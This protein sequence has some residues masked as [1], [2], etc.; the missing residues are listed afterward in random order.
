MA[1]WIDQT[2]KINQDAEI[3]LKE[4][5]VYIYDP[6]YERGVCLDP[7]SPDDAFAMCIALKL[8]AKRLQDIGENKKYWEAPEGGR[9]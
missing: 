9:V 7:V 8:A 5:V 2:L 1:R 6:K 3:A 4:R